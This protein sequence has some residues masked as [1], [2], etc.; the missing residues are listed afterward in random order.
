MDGA[1]AGTL[2]LVLEREIEIGRV[3]ADENGH[4]FREQAARQ[5]AADAEDLRQPRYDLG[6]ATDRQRFQRVPRLAPRRLHLR[7]RNADEARA[8][9][10]RPDRGNQYRS[11]R[12]AGRLSRGN[13][14][15]E[16]SGARGVTHGCVCSY[17]VNG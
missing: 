5:R 12:V 2:Q 15:G 17:R 8:R 4:A 6:Y 16:R 11:E 1:R 13:S 7:T 10:A 14:D 9:D 3:D